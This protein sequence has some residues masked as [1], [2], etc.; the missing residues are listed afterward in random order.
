MERN[1]GDEADSHKEGFMK[2]LAYISAACALLAAGLL[3]G[4]VVTGTTYVR[5]GPRPYYGRREVIVAPAPV[6]VVPAPPPAVIVA[7][8]PG[9]IVVHRAPPPVVVERITVSPGPEFVWIQGYYVAR[10]D[11]WVW[12]RG[13]YE[14]PPRPGMVWIGPR[15]E[16]HGAEY[17]FSMG[18]WR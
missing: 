17:R 9:V 8:A 3:S 10:G 7:P 1:Y 4:C 6:V 13:H 5:A 12:V 18:F 15:Y 11:D 14:R 16:E 2:T